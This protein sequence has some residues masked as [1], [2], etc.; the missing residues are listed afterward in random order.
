[1][2]Q[3]HI[4]LPSGAHLP[5][6]LYPYRK[7]KRSI[8]SHP[9]MIFVEGQTIKLTFFKSFFL[10]PQSITKELHTY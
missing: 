4:H 8:S 6:K 1:M 3:T 10:S 9:I 5:S 2:Y 7:N